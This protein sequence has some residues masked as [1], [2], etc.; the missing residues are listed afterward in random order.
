M[1][2]IML[3]IMLLGVFVGCSPK[4]NFDT[5]SKQDTKSKEF[6]GRTRKEVLYGGEDFLYT[7]EVD[8]DD[9][10]RKPE[11]NKGELFLMAGTVEQVMETDEESQYLVIVDSNPENILFCHFIKDNPYYPK[12][13]ILEGDFIKFKAGSLGLIDYETS[14]NSIKTVP[15][16]SIHQI[17]DSE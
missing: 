11:E 10:A 12:E 5:I 6:N 8:Y 15:N 3:L 14:G 7:G 4:E 16:V 13:R 17:I 1:K 9:L 2:K